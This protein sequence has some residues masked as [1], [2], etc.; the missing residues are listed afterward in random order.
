VAQIDI[1]DYV[2]I[3]DT[4]YWTASTRAVTELSISNS[5]I[6][7]SD[8]VGPGNDGDSVPYPAGTP[9]TIYRRADGVSNSTYIFSDG[10]PV[11]VGDGVI[12]KM[13]AGTET[14]ADEPRFHVGDT[15]IIDSPGLQ[16]E[17][18]TRSVRS[19]VNV[20]SIQAGHPKCEAKIQDNRML[21]KATA[22]EL[23]RSTVNRYAWP[24][25]ELK[26]GSWRLIPWLRPFDVIDLRD[27]RLFQ[28]TSGDADTQY[29]ER[30]YV[31]SVEHQISTMTT[32]VDL[33]G[34]RDI[35]E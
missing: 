12:V 24:H 30:V 26:G 18:A 1:W 29:K 28:H 2:T 11:D 34:T 9:V 23:T 14:L 17:K 35:D 3:G 25:Y 5:T 13:S 27:P 10:N 32:R 8:A 7:V 19:V 33:R 4:D 15:L 22:L 16:L 21:T 6:T 20:E 31:Q